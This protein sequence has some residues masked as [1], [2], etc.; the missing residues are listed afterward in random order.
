MW[1]VDK[2]LK[3]GGSMFAENLDLEY[4]NKWLIATKGVIESIGF[5]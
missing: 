2:H 4:V 5:E 1:Q 3:N